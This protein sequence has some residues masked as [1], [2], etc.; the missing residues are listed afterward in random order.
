MKRFWSEINDKLAIFSGILL[1]FTMFV[2]GIEVIARYI[3]NSPII[4]VVDVVTVL[5]PLFVFLPLASAE[6]HDKHIRVEFVTSRWRPIWQSTLDMFAY[7]CGLILMIL[8]AWVLLG[9][10]IDAFNAGQY[11][12]GLRRI[13]VWPSK[14]GMALGAALFAIQCLINFLKSG[15]NIKQHLLK[16]GKSTGI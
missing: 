8:M 2:I 16:T 10:A 9:F 13:R 15:G 11:L 6:I 3:F 14:F 12:P 4:G 1:G 7:L 5:I